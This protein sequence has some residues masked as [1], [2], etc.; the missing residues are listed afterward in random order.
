MCSVRRLHGQEMLRAYFHGR[1]GFYTAA[2]LLKADLKKVGWAVGCCA[3]SLER[4]LL[5]YIASSGGHCEQDVNA[6]LMKA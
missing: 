2:K 4:A 6:N 5:R 1:W 3:W